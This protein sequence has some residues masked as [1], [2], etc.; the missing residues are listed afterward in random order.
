MPANDFE[1]VELARF[2]TS[3]IQDLT[4]EQLT[5][6]EGANLEGLFTEW[7]T[8]LLSEA[9]ETEN[10][11]IAYD[12]KHLGT[13]NQHKIN[14][15]SISDNYE[16]VDLFISI[17][18][19]TE[20]L[21]RIMKDEVDTASKRITNF[22]KKGKY[23]D[24]FND[25]EESSTIF[26]FV[27]TLG[28]SK[29]LKENLVRVNAIILTDALYP[30]AVP[31]NAEIAGCPI[32]YRIIDM[33]YFYNIT[34]KSHIPIEIDFFEEGYKIPC[35]SI[36]AN[37]EY[38]S[39]LAILPGSSL[40]A[41]YERF[42]SRLL[43][44]NVRSFLQFTGKINKGIRA[45]IIN[46]PEMFLAFNNGIAATA[47]E[48]ELMQDNS[49]IF[50]KKVMDLQIVNGGQTTASIYHTAK[51]DKA[52]I[53]NIFVQLKISVIKDKINLSTIVSRISEYANTQ[54][55]VSMSD[56]SSNRPFHIEIEK[57]SR[58]IVTPH[59]QGHSN[60]TK[61]FYERARGQYKNARLR[62]GF[63]KAKQK[64]FD[65]KYPKKQLFKKEDVA[66]YIN[67]FEEV[68]DGSRLVVGPHFVVRG[69]QKNYVQFMNFN[70]IK[71]PDN[72]YYEDLI[73]KVI[74]FKKAENLYGIKPNAIG[75]M[76]YITVPYS[77]AYLGY[78]TKHELDLYKIWKNQQISDELSDFLYEL[79][80]VIELY[81]KKSAPGS[82]IGEWAKKEECWTELKKTSFNLDL[83]K[84]QIDLQDTANPVKRKKIS[85]NE[86]V[87]L[88]ILE[89]IEKIKS[90]PSETWKKMEDWGKVTGNLN[91]Y[92]C[93]IA[94]TLGGRIRNNSTI[95]DNERRIGIQIIDIV[96]DKAP[97]L[98]LEIDDINAKE[99]DVMI[100]DKP[101]IDINLIQRMIIYDRKHNILKPQ[102]FMFMN[103]IL[104]GKRSLSEV[105]V[106]H[107]QVSL[108]I[109]KKHG[110]K[111]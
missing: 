87:E 98:L 110:F 65:L 95:L 64:V 29:E 27:R 82:L 36:P 60:Q 68:F 11:R 18:K 85:D 5:R 31:D 48:I 9:G 3:I 58:N 37:S 12:E 46:E 44:Q 102:Y 73:A 99:S 106:E 75:D 42:G 67:T 45:T 26:D 4:N 54:N 35:I 61:W 47:E 19:G 76:R 71:K 6:E 79:M 78:I 109:L 97:E 57:L 53:S 56:L 50:I 108:E 15:Y 52:D 25:I 101:N 40:A 59:I 41:I 55:K 7:A 32:Y 100:I 91:Q 34:Q 49:G 2:Y 43:E 30:G 104:K 66:K 89:D 70:L 72:I 22:F 24:Y 92:Q 105:A 96:I 21:N 39:Y 86:T 28:A 63:T 93:N 88:Q 33:N 107:C 38:Q 69:N 84:I 8:D 10:V 16:T 62:E 80:K 90:V 23:K 14:A 81:I 83:S 94:F 77:I 20:E 103:N 111:Y 17:F 51:K 1:S 74:L 13:K